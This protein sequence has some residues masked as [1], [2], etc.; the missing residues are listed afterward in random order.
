M[1]G[2]AE[3]PS[4][5]ACDNGGDATA[6][7]NA[8]DSLANIGADCGASQCLGQIGNPAAYASCVSACIQDGVAGLSAACANCYGNVGRC[9]LENTC[10]AC[11]T[12]Y[13]GAS[14]Q[15]C[16]NGGMCLTTLDSCTG[17]PSE[18]CP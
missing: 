4:L 3:A 7:A 8:G 11:A 2:S 17:I 12:S 14:C 9:G 16:L 10:F 13:C 1:G 5:G 6:I 15:S 18:P